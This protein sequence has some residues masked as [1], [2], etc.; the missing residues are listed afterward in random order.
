MPNFANQ[1]SALL[2][3]V[4]VSFNTKELTLTAIDSALA[5]VAYSK[6][7][8]N[9]S[10]LIVVDN[11]STD[12]S[13]EALRSLSKQNKIVSCIYNSKNLGFSSANNQAI[14]LSRGK[15][16]LLLNS[17]TQAS[18]EAFEQ[19]IATFEST[20]RNNQTAQL[21]SHTGE[22]DNLGVLSAT[23]L[24]PDESLQ[25]QGGSLPTLLSLASHFLFLDDLPILG[26]WLPSTQHTGRNTK[27]AAGNTTL[28]QSGWVAA[29]AL[30]V[31]RSVFA[32]IG[33]LDENI[34]MYGED[35]E[36][37]LRARK[38]HFDCA[39]DQKAR[40]IHT[41]SA[42]GGSKN[43]ILGEIRGYIYI[44]AKHKPAAE[45][46]FARIILQMGVFLRRHIFATIKKDA[47][48][49]HIYSEA[50]QLLR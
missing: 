6:K 21:S 13:A 18:P 23:L 20:P 24:N 46:R 41:Q 40:I 33:L 14:V 43:A 19:L 15:Y 30:L 47:R 27:N 11:N 29:T 22:L 5:A 45:Q 1:Q 2:T 44:W 31:P 26:R 36:F 3:I 35:V 37:C 8:A 9:H 32:E 50:A 38:H 10:E 4:V 16:I 39:V 49:A 12:G 42:S 48:K 7:L 25:P 34:F 17:D 28:Q